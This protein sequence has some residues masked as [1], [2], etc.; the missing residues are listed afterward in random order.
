M[1]VATAQVLHQSQ[2]V[3]WFFKK[4]EEFGS[5]LLAKMKGRPTRPVG[6]PRSR[7]RAVVWWLALALVLSLLSL[8]LYV[9]FATFKRPD[10]EDVAYEETGDEAT[11][12]RLR[13]II[14]E[15]ME[16]DKTFSRKR[17]ILLSTGHGAPSPIAFILHTNFEFFF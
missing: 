10:G 9:M 6:P 7:R 5:E 14:E 3:N 11:G 16:N 13:R 2:I 12:E 4:F 8:Y 15:A 1:Q 17:K